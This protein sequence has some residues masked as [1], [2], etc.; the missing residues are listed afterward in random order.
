MSRTT[1]HVT[2]VLHKGLNLFEQLTRSCHS[3][4][5]FMFFTS[6]PL[7]TR[8]PETGKLPEPCRQHSFAQCQM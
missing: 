7:H 8:D 3:L 2:W 5:T 1:P 6:E 4:S